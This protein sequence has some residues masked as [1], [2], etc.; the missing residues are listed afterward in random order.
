MKN[1]ILLRTTTVVVL[2][3]M[4]GC[5]TDSQRTKTQGTA[6]GA[7]GGAIV[8]GGLGFL[9]AVLKGDTKHA[10]KYVAVGAG[11]GAVAGGVIGYNW[12]KRVAL[13]KEKYASEE[14]FLDASI[15]NAQDCTVAAQRENM[16]LR[17]QVA[18][19]KDQT[20]GLL[21]QY[22][23]GQVSR[24][25]IEKA[26]QEIQRQKAAAQD[27]V[28][29]IDQA[30][31]NAQNEKRQAQGGAADKLSSLDNEIAALKTQKTALSARVSDYA[32]IS[33]RLAV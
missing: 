13:R 4:M 5:A 20:D 21:A 24:G 26:H 27:Q 18:A 25:D 14:D 19:L 23:S 30:I 12:G 10:G 17:Q 29:H 3:A 16:Y 2:C 22:H 11:A 33:N 9:T 32:K 31:A 15:N 7:T 28:A 6:I 8:G 1:R